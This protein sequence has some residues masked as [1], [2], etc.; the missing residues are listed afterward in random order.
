MPIARNYYIP[1][2]PEGN[3]PALKDP[4]ARYWSYKSKVRQT[5]MYNVSTIMPNYGFFLKLSKFKI[6]MR[7]ISLSRYGIVLQIRL[8]IILL[9]IKLATW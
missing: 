3:W 5:R 8:I 4:W 6:L 7:E 1:E 9:T 2:P